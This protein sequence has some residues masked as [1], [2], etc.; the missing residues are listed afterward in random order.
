VRHDIVPDFEEGSP[1]LLYGTC[2][3]GVVLL[4]PRA[5]TT[6]GAQPQRD[7]NGL[8]G[9]SYHAYQFVIQCL[10][11]RLV[12]EPGREGFKG[13]SRV[14]LLAQRPASDHAS[15]V[16]ARGLIPPTSR[17]RSL[18]SSVTTPLYS[19]AVSRALR[20]RAVSGSLRIPY[21]VYELQ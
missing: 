2:F 8:H 3:I 15:R 16:A 21:F 11:V 6:L 10:E 1:D 5:S 14:V 18:A 20:S 12:P 9:L 19:T 17:S 4:A 13:L 7:V